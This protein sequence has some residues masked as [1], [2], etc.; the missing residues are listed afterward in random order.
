MIGF[1]A[2]S[3]VL[4]CAVVA[5]ALWVSRP[6]ILTAEELP[7]H[8]ADATRGEAIFYAT[9]CAS[10]HAA[11]GAVE[12]E[13]LVLAGGLRFE[14]DFGIFY[15]PNISSDATHG[16]GG[17][18]EA[19]FVSALKHG[20]SP[21]RE[22]YYP[23][24]P[25]SSYARMQV[26]DILDLKAYMDGLPDDLTPSKPHE[27]GFPFNIRLT[28]GGWK[29]LFLDP[30]PVIPQSDPVLARGQYLVEAMGHCAECHTPRNILGGLDQ[31]RW[32]A[33]GP[34]PDGKGKIPDITPASLDWI[35]SDIAYYLESGFTPEFDSAGGSMVGVIENTSK[36][37]PQDR[38]AIAAYLKALPSG[39]SQ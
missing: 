33:G 4:L 10:C 9:G 11:P 3:F 34:N 5:V 23:A 14:T 22:H 24:F 16:I 6:K 36:L 8:Q 37:S 25:Y 15:A 2:R 29:A 38:L 26:T 18:T 1:L 39:A 7:L 28:L 12:D 30:D 19:E 27:L 21:N 32:L 31:S 13:K 20:T 35:E 17:W